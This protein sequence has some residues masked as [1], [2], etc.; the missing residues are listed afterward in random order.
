MCNQQRSEGSLPLPP[1]WTR[2]RRGSSGCTSIHLTD[3]EERLTA[4][5]LDPET[6]VGTQCVE[7]RQRV[8]PG[9]DQQFDC[10][11]LAH[12]MSLTDAGERLQR[13][14]TGCNGE[15]AKVEA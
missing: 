10:L 6:L 5:L 11:V 12:G 14:R 8:D 7:D 9:V 3:E 2:V 15:G 13:I 4:I 1:L